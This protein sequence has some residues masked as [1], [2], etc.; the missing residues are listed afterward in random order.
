MINYLKGLPIE[1]IK[2]ISN[3]IILLLEVN[4][5]GYEM[6]IPSRFSRIINPETGESLQVFTHLQIR[7]DQQI[8]Y[9]FASAAERDLFRQLTNVSGIGSPFK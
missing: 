5:I 1:I 4:Q 6:Q 8:L 2:G 9:G 3:R 7:E